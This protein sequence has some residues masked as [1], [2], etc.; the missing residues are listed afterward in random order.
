[1]YTKNVF[2]LE[3]YPKAYI[4]YTSPIK[5]KCWD[6]AHF[7]RATAFELMTDFDSDDKPMYYIYDDD[8]FLVY[9]EG[10]GDY[11]H[12]YGE[13]IMTE[14][15]IK[16]LYGIGAGTWLWDGI[17]EYQ[18][19]YLAVCIEDFLYEYDTYHY[20]DE[21]LDRIQTVETIKNQLKELSTLQQV[22]NIWNDDSLTKEMI[23]EKLGK[24][25]QI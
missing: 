6:M 2:T 11:I 4:G 7:E 20:K 1:M 19:H 16:H 3:D 12:V 10:A 24:E 18:C 9:D 17:N 25:L 8:C 13:D 5:W 15:G 14:D 21:C 23:F 22:Y